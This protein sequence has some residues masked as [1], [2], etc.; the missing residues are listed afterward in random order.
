MNAHAYLTEVE[1]S[2]YLTEL[3]VPYAVRTLSNHRSSGGG[4][5]YRKLGRRVRYRKSDIDAWLN[6]APVMRSTSEK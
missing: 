6:A 1:T 4:I 5:P 3:G 2:E